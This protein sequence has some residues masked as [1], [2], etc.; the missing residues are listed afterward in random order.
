MN[1][2][3]KIGHKAQIVIVMD[4]FVANCK[5]QLYELASSSNTRNEQ[6]RGF[7][8]DIGQV[9]QLLDQIQYPNANQILSSIS[10]KDHGQLLLDYIKL[11]K[12]SRS[13]TPYNP[14]NSDTT[15]Q[16]TMVLRDIMD[17]FDPSEFTEADAAQYAEQTIQQTVDNM[18]K[19][20]QR[21]LSAVNSLNSWH[22]SM[23]RIIPSALG[24][25][26]LSRD[27]YS[28][29][30]DSALIELGFGE[31]VPSFS[32]F[33]EGS[34]IQIDDI[35]EAGDTDFFTDPESQNDY[36]SLV[37]ELRHPGYG[38]SNT[39][40]TLYTARPAADRRQYLEATTLPPNLFLTNNY[41]RACGIGRDF[42][43]R[44]I[45]RVKIEEK[46]LIQTLDTPTD[47]DYQIAGQGAVPVKRI[48]LIDPGD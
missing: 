1:W 12:W 21:I 3:Q 41:Q 31:Y 6:L 4:D 38:S 30:T 14:D 39:L 11:G 48:K 9:S 26:Y 46:Y 33:V 44:D 36:F 24:E 23:V 40:L 45:W 19:I 47:K 22:T 27:D 25:I 10:A 43:G 35:L 16:L 8:V 18:E 32:Y 34:D 17:H 5:A 20:K 2:L 7:Q 29:P 15:F 13:Q 28:T 37:K 42:G